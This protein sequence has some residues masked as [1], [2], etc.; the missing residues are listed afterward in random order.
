M[1]RTKLLCL[2]AAACL[3]AALPC[4]ALWG[5]AWAY[6]QVKVPVNPNEPIV[7]TKAMYADLLCMAGSEFDCYRGGVQFTYDPAA[8]AVR[9]TYLPPTK[10]NEGEGKYAAANAAARK[11]Y[12]KDRAEAHMKLVLPRIQSHISPTAVSAVGAF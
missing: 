11:N 6:A 7:L 1:S 10:I 5:E 3:F 2:A 4:V 8:D 9:V 12:V